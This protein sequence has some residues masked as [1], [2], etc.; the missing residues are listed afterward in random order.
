MVAEPSRDNS[1]GRRRAER[2]A[3]A[4][5]LR[6][7]AEPEGCS[8]TLLSTNEIAA[9]EFAVLKCPYGR[10][11]IGC[12]QVPKCRMIP[13]PLLGLLAAIYDAALD[14][15]LWPSVLEKSANFVGG[16]ASALFL[17]DV[18]QH[19]QQ[20]VFTW[21]PILYQKLLRH[22]YTSRP[23]LDRIVSHRR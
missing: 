7:Q 23:V 5:T 2:S 13:E 3:L 20:D 11:R 4:P 10:R 17:K 22:V 14:S 6:L 18:A 1:V 21:G 12:S 19:P 16:T 9:T 8:S 15:S